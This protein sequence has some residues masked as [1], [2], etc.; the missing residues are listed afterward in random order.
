MGAERKRLFI[1]K[2]MQNNIEDLF[3]IAKVS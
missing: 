1:L 2:W 3:E